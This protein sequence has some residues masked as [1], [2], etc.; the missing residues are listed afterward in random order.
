MT[1]LRNWQRLDDV[2]AHCN[3]P[4]KILISASPV[5][6]FYSLDLQRLVTQNLVIWPC[7]KLFT[8]ALWSEKTVWKFEIHTPLEKS[9]SLF[10][11]SATIISQIM[12]H[13]LSAVSNE[14]IP[15]RDCNWK[16]LI[17]DYSWID[18][19]LEEERYL[20]YFLRS[21][22]KHHGLSSPSYWMNTK[23]YSITTKTRLN[24]AAV[25]TL[26][27]RFVPQIDSSQKGGGQ[28]CLAEWS[29]IPEFLTHSSFILR[30]VINCTSVTALRSAILR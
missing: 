12:H 1:I 17:L 23:Q 11:W 8:R 9:D 21:C 10:Y 3:L 28:G 5:L 19:R 7:T 18:Y 27:A 14:L 15:K 13:L 24:F 16:S 20:N 22:S 30:L 26:A 4:R 6:N 2:L 29:T 25:S